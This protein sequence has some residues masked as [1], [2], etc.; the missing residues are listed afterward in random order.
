MHEGNTGRSHQSNYVSAAVILGVDSIDRVDNID[1]K[2]AIMSK[3]DS[4]QWIDR[5]DSSYR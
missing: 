4:I 2:T 3:V 1:S 5:V